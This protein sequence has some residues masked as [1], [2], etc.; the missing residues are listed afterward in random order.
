MIREDFTYC[1]EVTVNE[2]KR[3]AYIDRKRNLSMQIL[4]F[5]DVTIYPYSNET[6]EYRGE[7]F[8]RDG[9]R[10]DNVNSET[11]YSDKPLV[12][13][14]LPSP[15]DYVDEAIY[16]GSQN[17]CWGHYFTDGL[18]KMWSIHNPEF[19]SLVSKKIPI[20]FVSDSFYEGEMPFSWK[21]LIDLLGGEGLDIRPLRKN[22]KFGN[23]HIPTNCIF[24]TNTGRYYTEEY[25]QLIS[26][27]KEKALLGFNQRIYPKIYLSR[28]KLVS[29]H[30]EFGER[31]IE[32][33]FKKQGYK[34]IYPERLS[35][36]QQV[37]LLWHAQEVAG[38]MGS[39][40][41]NFV[42]CR[43]DAKVSIIRKAWYTNDFQYVLNQEAGISAT[44]I[45]AHLSVFVTEDTN[46]GPFYMYINEN[47]ARFFADHYGIKLSKRFNRRLFQKYAMI[48][49]QRP[50]F[51][52]RNIAPEYYYEKMHEEL[53]NSPSGIK[54]IYHGILR[55]FGRDIQCIIKTIIKRINR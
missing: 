34:I 38:T 14:S 28:T 39:I 47:V 20:Y 49:L 19:Q 10:V 31:A 22:T 24:N 55:L 21:H 29:D 44:Y 41:H 48:C 50:H 37:G 25:E 35:F 2:E 36:E 54:K 51:E 6:K 53:Q 4:Q 3:L 7:V 30:A 12:I 52:K 18:S 32:R 42:F 5:R 45:D 26:V 23:L 8:T 15:E 11:A 40:S 16:I 17:M 46:E 43:P 13:E 9:V 33:V 27:L 1:D